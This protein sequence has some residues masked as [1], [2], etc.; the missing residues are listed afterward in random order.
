M[1]NMEDWS[2]YKKPDSLRSCDKKD[3][4]ERSKANDPNHLKVEQKVKEKQKEVLIKEAG[5]SGKR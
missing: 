2:E 3:H 1:G 4:F 5:K